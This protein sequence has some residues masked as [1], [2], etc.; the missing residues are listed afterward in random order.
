[1]LTSMTDSP[2]GGSQKWSPRDDSVF[3][4]VAVE[5]NIDFMLM[6]VYRFIACVAFVC[7]APRD[8]GETKKSGQDLNRLVGL[9]S[10]KK[11]SSR[12]TW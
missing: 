11:Q 9:L 7:L 1:M 12:V 2:K 6:D 8:Q 5:Q 10:V 4:L 3:V